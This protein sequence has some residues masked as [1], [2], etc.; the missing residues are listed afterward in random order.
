MVLGLV[1]VLVG[2]ALLLRPK[3]NEYI[4]EKQAEEEINE[5]FVEYWGGTI[6]NAE[7]VKNGVYR[8]ITNPHALSLFPELYQAM[9]E[10][11]ETIYGNGQE[12]ISDPWAYQVS[13][14]DLSRF[15]LE[16]K[17]IG[18]LTIPKMKFQQP[19]YVGATSKHLN[20]GVAQIAISSMPIGGVN[21]N[22]VIAGHRGWNGA[23]YMRYIDVLE[24]G[25][26][27]VVTNFWKSMI[28]EVKEIMVIE[29]YEAEKIMIQPD[30]DLVT[31]LTCHPYGSGGRFRYLV[32]CERVED[33]P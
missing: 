20:D 9:Q 6:Q 7:D 12:G 21:T 27:I 33:A 5:F 19:I 22:C 17:P 2:T 26:I 8:S 13:A 29:P 31:I 15:G 16:D 32:F 14:M 1:M 4:Q 23:P 30:R 3:V 18:V 24:P 28:Y 10:Y 25:D 11:N